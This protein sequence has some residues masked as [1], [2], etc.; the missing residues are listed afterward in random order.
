MPKGAILRPFFTKLRAFLP[1]YEACNDPCMIRISRML[2]SALGSAVAVWSSAM[3]VS[4]WVRPRVEPEPQEEPLSPMME[5][6]INRT[7]PLSV[8]QA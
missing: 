3:A 2:T 1:W 5:R 7:T 6:I 4:V 8:R